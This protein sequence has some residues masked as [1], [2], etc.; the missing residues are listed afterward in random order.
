MVWIHGGAFTMGAGRHR[1]TT[2]PSLAPQG[3]VVVVTINYRLGVARLP[4]SRPTST[5][6][7]PGSGNHGILDQIAALEWVRDNIAAFG[8]DPD[9]VTIFGESAGGG[10]IAAL[11]GAPAADGLYHKAIIESGP[12]AIAPPY[13][14]DLLTTALLSALGQPDGGI[15]TFR[16]ADASRLI[17]AQ[18]DIGSLDQFGRDRDHAVDGSGAGLRP[19]VDGVVVHSSSTQVIAA[20]ASATSRC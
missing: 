10:S 2:A 18:I 16:N 17:Q 13:K 11:L 6:S 9:N 12:V 14:P 7:S 20:R 19:S 3:D 8:G 4:A 5:P 15:D 1:G